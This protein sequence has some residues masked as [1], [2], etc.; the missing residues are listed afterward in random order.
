MKTK[1]FSKQ[2]FV[3]KKV[4][5]NIDANLGIHSRRKKKKK[6]KKKRE[7]KCRSLCFPEA[8]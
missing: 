7:K 1:L 8:S 3:S 4:G 2:N 6:K 5:S